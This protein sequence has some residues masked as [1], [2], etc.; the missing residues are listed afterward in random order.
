MSRIVVVDDERN[1]RAAFDEIL[2]SQG[3]TI[4]AYGTAEAA[5]ADVD[6]Q[7]PDLVIMDVCMPGIGG[8]EALDRIRLRQPKL[9][10]IIMTGQGTMQTAIEATKRGAF[11][12]HLK[13]FEPEAMLATVE[14]ALEAS[15][16]M[17]R[18]VALGPDASVHSED[19]IIGQGAA[20]QQV[21]KQIGRVAPTDA[22]VLIRGE[23]GTGKELVARAI[24][25]HGPRSTGPLV[26]I[27][28]VAIPETLLES[29]LFGHE[30]GAFTGAVGRRLGK[31]EQADGGTIFLDEIGDLP[32]S[33]QAKILRVLQEKTFQ[34]VGGNQTLQVDVRVLAATNRDLESAIAAGSFREDL[35]HRLNVVTIAVPPLR[36]RQEDIPRLIDYFL[37]RFSREL[38]IATPPVAPEALEMLR[39]YSWPG[40]VREL[41]HTIHRTLIFTRGH[42]IQAADLLPLGSRGAAGDDRQPV[43]DLRQLAQYVRAHL[44]QPRSDRPFD[45]VMETVERLLLVEALDRCQGNQSQ[46]A[47]L[48]G[49]ARPTLHAKLQK[50]GLHGDRPRGR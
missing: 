17:R 4:V 32:L 23:S 42:S 5:L 24:Y 41:E 1:V 43:A 9:P 45:D 3:H 49:I 36:Q 2:S 27:N 30:R 22:T 11:D 8:L 44:D 35:Y 12:Y 13:P 50:L 6:G 28:C 10:V 26:L 19:A 48:L 18:H 46:A 37:Q 29:E 31:F 39:G 38:K 40:N 34:R 14:R 20:M 33:L 16:L 15:R 47:R 21:Y 25:Q 7:P